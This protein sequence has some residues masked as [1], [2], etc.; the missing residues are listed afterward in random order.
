MVGALGEGRRDLVRFPSG[1]ASSAE[2]SGCG[3]KSRAFV[4]RDRLGF[5]PTERHKL[6]KSG[7][8]SECG[9]AGWEAGIPTNRFPSVCHRSQYLAKSFRFCQFHDR[10]LASVFFRLP[11]FADIAGAMSLKMSLG[12]SD[13]EIVA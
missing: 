7:A 12:A 6:L 4:R 2:P 1:A 3:D 5:G 8:L 9:C 11:P 10:R 13:S